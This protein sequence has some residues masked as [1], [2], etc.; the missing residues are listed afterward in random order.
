MKTKITLLFSML[1]YYLAMGNNIAVS[2]ISLENYNAAESWAHVEFD[3]SWENSW[4]LSSGPS[5]WDA[6]WVFV[7]YRINNGDWV[8]AVLNQSNTN[9]APGS[10]VEITS[11]GVG[12]LIY[13]DADGSGNLNLQD[14]QLQWNT[15]ST[16]SDDIIDIKVFAIEMVYVPEGAFYVGGRSDNNVN[17]FYNANGITSPYN[18]TSEAAITVAN[19]PGN[20][21]YNNDN[22][23]S[24]DQL[25][26]IPAEFPKG[27]GAFY[28]MKYEVTQS[29]WIGFFNTLN[30]FQKTNQDVTGINGKNS[31]L[32]VTRNG[33]SWVEGTGASATTTN[34]DVPLNFVNTN[35]VNTYMDWAGLRPM[36]ELEYEKASRGPVLPKPGEFAWGSANV[37][38]TPYTYSNLGSPSESVTNPEVSTGNAIYSST[39]GT[40]SGPKRSGILASSATNKNREETGGSY[41]GVMELSGNV[42]ERCVTVGNPRGRLF[43]GN[44]G[45]GGISPDGNGTV[46]NWPLSSGEGYGYKGASFLNGSDF[47]RTS[48]R[49]DAAT[50]FNATNDRIGFR[51]ART[52]PN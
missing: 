21:Y 11:D 27:F 28:L 29:Q 25:G 35:S 40:P 16:T 14:I 15:G 39:N 20:L 12:A 49:F 43:N 3:L 13:R 36:T 34:P 23:G 47:M 52:A 5:N 30:E 7:K 8:H 33:I 42:Y 18:I 22:S 46:T 48:D 41:Y 31:D 32:E 38:S 9:A 51:A 17:K 1:M 4:R 26:P 50:T 19:T 44:H 24:G 2:N 10:I 6:A 37:A 45:N